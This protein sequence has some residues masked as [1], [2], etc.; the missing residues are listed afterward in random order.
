MS[1]ENV[2]IVRRIY[3]GVGEGRLSRRAWRSRSECHAV[4]RPD[5]PSSVC[6]LALRASRPSCAASSSIGSNSRSRRK[7]FER[8]ATRSR[9][10]R[11]ARQGQGEWDRGGH[12]VLPVV[13]LPGRKDRADG[14]RDVR[15]PKPSKPPGCGSR[16]DIT[17]APSPP[18]RG[19]TARGPVDRPRARSRTAGTFE[20][21][22]SGGTSA[23]A[24]TGQVR[25]PGGLGHVAPPGGLQFSVPWPRL[26]CESATT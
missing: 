15:E 8:W 4:I 18:G 25:E 17:C 13:H 3:E 9:P 21:G 1:Q 10:R 11:P 26:I 19:S 23:I 7:T 24:A 22:A 14:E 16:A 12:P 2:E 5:F 6:S 20:S